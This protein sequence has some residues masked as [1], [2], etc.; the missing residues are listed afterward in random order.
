M[1]DRQD[2]DRFDEEA[3][4]QDSRSGEKNGKK[5]EKKKKKKRGCG[6]FITLLLL[7]CGLAAGIQ[8]SGRFDFR[9]M[10]FPLIPKIPKVGEPLASFLDIPPEYSL[11]VEERRKMELDEWERELANMARS[12]DIRES[13]LDALSED[14]S[15]R[16][17]E[18]D[19]AR[20]ELAAKLE[21]LSNDMAS[22]GGISASAAAGSEEIGDIV[23]TFEEMSP[24]NAAAILEKLN[25]N[26]AVA[27]L[28]G[29]PEDFRAKALGRMEAAAAAELMEQLN[30][31]QKSRGK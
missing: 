11:T 7:T 27:V 5:K 26:L 10:L 8:A 29:L 3:A 14:L 1:A 30:E 23:K 9:P 16:E 6:F 22:G 24:K 4:A 28:D 21:A 17:S 13:E 12:L 15:T 20:G 25:P 2:L 31:L 18:L 19:G